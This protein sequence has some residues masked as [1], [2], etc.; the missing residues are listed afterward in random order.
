MRRDFRDAYNRELALLKERSRDFAADYPGI[1]DRLG[2]LLDENLDPAI[3]GLLEGAAFL[4]ARVQE[5]IDDQFKTFTHE[6]LEQIF[7]DGTAPTASAM[8]VR[9]T[10][11]WA[12]DAL[13]EGMTLPAG[14]IL[15]ARYK[16]ADKRVACR[17]T[18]SE[19]LTIW[20]VALTEAKYHSSPGPVGALGQDVTKGCKAGLVLNLARFDKAG[21]TTEA[22]PFSSLPMDELKV[23]FVGEY[24][25]MATLYEQ[26]LCDTL[27]V[28]IRWL[29][30][31]GD[32]RFA[33]LPPHA[34]EQIGF[35]EDYPLYPQDERLFPGFSTLRDVFVF[36]RKILGFRLKGLRE[37]LSRIDRTDLKIVFELDASNTQ[38]AT[39][40]ELSDF[41][42][43]CAPAVNLFP[44]YS[45]SVRLDRRRHAYVVQPDSS[46]VTHY[47][48]HRLLDVWAHYPGHRDKVRVQPLYAMSEGDTAPRDTLYYTIERRP[49]RLTDK[50]RRFGG[51]R[52]RYRG[53]ETFITL[54]E[55]PDL[56]PAQRLSIRV[57]CSNRH[58]PEYLPIAGGEDDFYSIEDRTVRFTCVGGP[59]PP[60]ESMTEV[61]SHGAH[62]LTSGETYWRL[63]SFLALNHRGLQNR[64]DGSGAAALRE[65]LRLFATLSDN[66]Q[67]AQIEAVK[68]I[69]TRPI[70]R[71]IARSDGYHPARGLE[72]KI[73]FDEDGFEGA[74]VMVLAAAIDRF[75]AD[76]SAVN[77]FTQLVVATRQRGIIKTFP[78]RL[79]SGPLL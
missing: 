62:R 60:R 9:A 4:A 76:Y 44:D 23:N 78:P 36:P 70:T 46:P 20:P 24:A 30:K 49:R 43:H 8:L 69:T 28:S 21:K 57:L 33:N 11:P 50:E 37:I 38:L 54:Y 53:T 48:I 52:Y 7:P 13:N 15:E 29:D 47:E 42:L 5:N 31:N 77:S 41:A 26:V 1:A 65:C 10:P 72:V 45:N 64:G 58:L 71:T 32:A 14:E 79:G 3:Q 17:Y 59:T 25:L 6:L 63:I 68:E 12:D 2:G 39:R 34:I 74:N 67:E 61:E 40:L 51:T 35:D 18:L 27:R 55:P 75:L 19:P 73:T 56:D 22:E 16:D 66:V